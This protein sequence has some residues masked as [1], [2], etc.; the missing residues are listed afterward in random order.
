MNAKQIRRKLEKAL[1]KELEL[2]AEL[3]V[4][5]EGPRSREDAKAEIQAG[6]ERHTL[7]Y[8]QSL[9]GNLTG[10]SCRRNPGVPPHVLAMNLADFDPTEF[11]KGTI[12]SHTPTY[13]GASLLPAL[14]SPFPPSWRLSCWRPSIAY[15][16][17]PS[18]LARTP[19]KKD[20]RSSRPN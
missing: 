18:A 16:K 7:N 2:Q 3:A 20:R 19:G 17:A 9:R 5:M 11:L 12:Q 1:K 6:L 4:C 13:T 8:Q 14:A 15:P 10:E